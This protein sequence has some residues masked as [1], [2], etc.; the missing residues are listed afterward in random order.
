YSEIGHWSLSEVY[1]NLGDNRRGI[2]EL[3]KALEIN[4][5]NPDVMLSKGTLLCFAGQFDEGLKLMQQG[6][7]FNKHYPQWYFWNLGIGLFAGHQWQDCID[8]LI[9]MDEQNKD[10][11]TFLAASYVLVENMVEARACFAEISRIDPEV[12]PHKI[13]IAH[14]YLAADTLNL[15]IDSLRLLMADMKPQDRLRIVKP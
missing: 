6:I 8:A 15:M 1:C 3:E 5:N 13:E 14:S 7:K 2:S 10:T 11:L 12:N 4:P 9:R